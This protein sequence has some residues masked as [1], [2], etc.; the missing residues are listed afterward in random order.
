MSDDLISYWDIALRPYSPFLIDAFNKLGPKDR[1]RI[2]K[3]YIKDLYPIAKGF[4]DA[5][6][7][8]EEKNGCN[9]ELFCCTNEKE[10]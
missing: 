2:K 10:N 9:F 8:L 6:K 7:E 1:L 3:N 4:L 5:Q